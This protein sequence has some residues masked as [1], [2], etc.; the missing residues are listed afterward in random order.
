MLI[1]VHEEI[2][3]AG[4]TVSDELRAPIEK[5]NECGSHSHQ[6]ILCKADCLLAAC[7]EVFSNS[8]QSLANAL[9]S[10]VI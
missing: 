5:L 6:G 8:S 2:V 9:F 1:S 10:S 3:N 4:L 7:F